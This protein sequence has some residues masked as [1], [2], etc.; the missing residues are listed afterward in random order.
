MVPLQRR[1]NLW[2]WGENVKRWRSYRGRG[3]PLSTQT[4]I[5]IID[6]CWSDHF[7]IH[8]WWMRV[9]EY[10][11]L[12]NALQWFTIRKFIHYKMCMSSPVL[13][14]TPLTYYTGPCGLSFSFQ[15]SLLPS[16]CN[17]YKRWISDKCSWCEWVNT[18]QTCR[19]SL[20]WKD[21]TI[22]SCDPLKFQKYSRSSRGC[23][24]TTNMMEAAKSNKEIGGKLRSPK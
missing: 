13:F 15:Y 21:K 2:V 9:Y 19:C 18:S 17:F 5:S 11:K 10:I 22:F 7:R 16:L 20:K 12:F 14:W 1:S 6:E 24:A 4:S 3:G 23:G 8:Q